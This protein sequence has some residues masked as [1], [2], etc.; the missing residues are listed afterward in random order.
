MQSLKKIERKDRRIKHA[1]IRFVP[2]IL[3]IYLIVEAFAAFQ[4]EDKSAVTARNKD[5]IKD[6]TTAMADKLDNI[7]ANSLKSIEAL[8]KLCASDIENGELNSVYLAELEKVAQFDHMRFID[9]TGMAQMSTGQKIDVR[10][11]WYYIDGMKGND[12]I[13][14][15]PPKD[16]SMAYIVFYAP[17]FIRG[18]VAGILT[19]SFDEYTIK[20]LLDYKVYGAQASAGIVNMD[21]KSIIPLESM[22]LQQAATQ[23]MNKDNFRSFLY[24]SKFEEEDRNN[25]IQAYAT[26]TA[27]SY[28]YK[29]NGDEIEGYIA[30]LLTVP[31]SV[32]SNFPNEASKSLYSMGIQ[33]GRM[34]QILLILIFVSYIVYL[35]IVQFLFR[36]IESREN[37]LADYIAKAENAIAKVIIIVD[38]EKGTF[39]DLSVM[40]M[41]FPRTGFIDKLRDGFIRLND[42]LQNGNDFKRFFDVSIMERKVLPKIPSVVFCSPRPDGGK[43]FITM[44]YV[45]VVVKKNVVYKG[46]ILFRN[47]TAEKSKEIEAN[48]KLSQALNAAREASKAKTSFLFN[49]SHDIRTPM[50]A[51]MG[52]TAMAK[53]HLDSPE[54]IK[55]YLDKIDIAGKQLLS[56]VNQ[57]LEM[58]S[59]ESGK[60]I[61]SEKKCNLENLIKALS[62]TYGSHAETKGILFTATIINIE[63]Q[64]VLIDEDRL[65][66]IAAN[67]IGNA[68]KYTNENGT[69]MCTLEEKKCDRDGYGLYLLVVEDTGIGMSSEF[70]EHIYD[71]FTRESSSTVSR[72]QG[73]GLG[74]T[75]VKKLT[76]LM[77]GSIQIESQKGQGSKIT[78]ALP[79]K[80]CN[81]FKVDAAEQKKITTIPLKG[82][83][84]LLVE[85]NEMNRE[86]A[87]ELLTEAGLIVDT[88]NDG[89]VAVDKIR[90]A[91]PY[92][93]ELVLMDV[94]MPRMNGYEATQEIRK[95][96]DP[97]KSRI[98]IIA[99]T[100]NAFEEDRKNALDAGMNGHLA[101]PIDVQKLIQTLMEFRQG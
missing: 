17:I 83:K 66:Q 93:Y 94:Q 47:I 16:T 32:Y 3:V 20:R 24:T 90:K 22:R 58:S 18:K 78:V 75:I 72:I 84:V 10:D 70:I 36:R 26:R 61:L 4:E 60:I 42:D 44:T 39:E 52:F 91:Q 89:D 71:E 29:E 37:Q 87:E 59:I 100:A 69:I 85:D 49:M 2:L 77:G 6:I 1:I 25:I 23:G 101:K 21:G 15:I 33:A 73:T 86:I 11:K 35:L 34:L 55:K 43:E 64:H 27:T 7:F 38:A 98:P 74:M 28:K 40:P 92:E 48:E 19:S 41:P 13:I 65:N 54:M 30:P 96:K 76:D 88:A 12:G 46:I 81:T 5:Y 68:I 95:L 79:M 80:W 62:T 51:V 97:R 99:M 8:A 82:M 9:T 53:K 14:V 56:L 57:V 67:I 45:P 31:L 63:H 50:N